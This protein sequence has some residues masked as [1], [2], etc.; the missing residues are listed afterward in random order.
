[1]VFYHSLWQ[2]PLF[3]ATKSR[4]CPR[5]IARFARPS[6]QCPST[7]HERLQSGATNSRRLETTPAT[8]TPQL[9]VWPIGQLCWC[10]FKVQGELKKLFDH[11]AANTCSCYLKE[12]KWKWLYLAL[13]WETDWLN[14]LYLARLRLLWLGHGPRHETEQEE[15]DDRGLSSEGL[16]HL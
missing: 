5:S 4:W 1:M 8:T 11:W 3:K 13:V 2:T 14:W 6:C 15:I 16:R 12:K 9:Q 10:R 7:S